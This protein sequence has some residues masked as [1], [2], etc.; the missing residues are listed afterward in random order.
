MSPVQEYSFFV[1]LFFLRFS[2]FPSRE[3]RIFWGFEWFAG[4]HMCFSDV[5]NGFGMKTQLFERK[6]IVFSETLIKTTGK[7]KKTK[8]LNIPGLFQDASLTLEE[9]R[10][11][12]VLVLLV[13]PVAF[14]EFL[15]KTLVFLML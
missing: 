1:C 5:L 15:T 14:I 4:E 8:K 7:T 6:T 13:L 12:S 9:S 11:S 2:L 10:N 3:Q